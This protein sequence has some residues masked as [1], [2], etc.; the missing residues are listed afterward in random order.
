MVDIKSDAFIPDWVIVFKTSFVVNS[1]ALNPANIVISD[2]NEEG[3]ISF[4]A[5]AIAVK[6][7]AI[8][9]NTSPSI[10]AV[11][12][13]DSPTSLKVLN[14]S[15]ISCITADIPPS[16]A[17]IVAAFP[18]V[19]KKSP[20]PFDMFSNGFVI[21]FPSFPPYLPIS[22]KASTNNS[23]KATVPAT[24]PPSIFIPVNPEKKSP[25]PL[26]IS[27]IILNISVNTPFQSMFNINSLS[28]SPSFFHGIILI[29]SSNLLNIVFIVSPIFSPI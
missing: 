11:S 10:I 12:P 6:P 3:S 25:K 20:K 2:K 15:V 19:L 1:T 24:S 27:F 13:K 8:A 17:T 26:N 23:I 16:T 29:N 4:V 21:V 7:I 18:N 5:S 22:L 28:A 9:P 14:K